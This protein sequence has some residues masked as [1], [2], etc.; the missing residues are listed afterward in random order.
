M[1]GAV[2]PLSLV[3]PPTVAVSG[4]SGDGGEAASGE[5]V[6]GG[7]SA[8]SGEDGTEPALAAPEGTVCGGLCSGAGLGS[9]AGV[10]RAAEPPVVAASGGAPALG[11]AGSAPRTFR[12]GGVNGSLAGALPLDDCDDG[13][14]VGL[15][16]A[17]SLVRL[18]GTATNTAS[19]L[20]VSSRSRLRGGGG[21]GVG[22]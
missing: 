19:R 16:G 8:V 21:S 20:L 18:A 9:G 17:V 7:A 3:P 12:D 22:A 4:A 15:A 10:R 1:P 5:A 2:T 13:V 14:V 6:S 11:I